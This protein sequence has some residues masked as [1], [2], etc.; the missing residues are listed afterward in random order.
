M[1]RRRTGR[2]VEPL[3]VRFQCGRK[4]AGV[5]HRRIQPPSLKSDSCNQS[6]QRD[7]SGSNGPRFRSH[8][9]TLSD[10]ALVYPSPLNFWWRRFSLRNAPTNA[11]IKSP[12]RS[13]NGIRRHNPLVMVI[14]EHVINVPLYALLTLSQPEYIAPGVKF[15]GDIGKG[16]ALMLMIHE[17][18][19]NEVS[20]AAPLISNIL[21]P[22]NFSKRSARAA[23][24]A[25]RL[26][27]RFD[28][29]IT[30][31]HVERPIEG[32]VYWTLETAWWAKEQIA[33]LFESKGKA[34]VQRIVSLNSDIAE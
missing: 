5:S 9:P 7:D 22:V 21:V 16:G 11:S 34:D 10:C 26:D 28:A 25:L 15:R 18:E 24:F 30:L 20:K 19:T 4:M 31:L 17:N 14:L 29:K 1:F 6:S 27:R 33:N 2:D 23:S 3:R 32:D 8:S 12:Q 13:S